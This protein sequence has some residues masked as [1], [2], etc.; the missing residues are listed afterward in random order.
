[1]NVNN[2]D[3]TVDIQE[4]ISTVSGEFRT[5]Q[6]RIGGTRPDNARFVPPPVPEMHRALDDFEKFIH[7]E[8]AFLLLIKAGL[9]H[10]QFETIHPFSD[11]NGR[12][13]RMLITLFLW[14]EKLLEMPVLYLS[15][16]FKKHQQLYYEKLHDYHN[17][18]VFEWL[19]L[20]L[21]TSCLRSACP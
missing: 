8:D 13:G 4:K 2:I 19:G 7:A 6:N 20:V 17:G 12:T 5:S 16:F 14:K 21:A 1:M 11:G 10:S 9:L 3:K 15:S 18:N